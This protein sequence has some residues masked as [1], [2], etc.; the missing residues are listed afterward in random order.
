M[1]RLAGEGVF[2]YIFDHQPAIFFVN[3]DHIKAASD[4]VQIVLFEV[5][6]RSGDELTLFCEG[7]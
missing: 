4:I 7:N 1:C 2:Q 3:L 5:M 6:L